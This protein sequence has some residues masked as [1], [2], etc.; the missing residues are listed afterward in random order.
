MSGTAILDVLMN[1]I[2]AMLAIAFLFLTLVDS[3]PAATGD[4]YEEN[5]V[6]LRTLSV[7]SFVSNSAPL[8]PND[9][10]VPVQTLTKNP[11]IADPSCGREETMTLTSL[12][13]R[14]CKG[15]Q[16]ADFDGALPEG[17][18]LPKPFVGFRAPG[19]GTPSGS[20]NS[21]SIVFLPK[22]GVKCLHTQYT[23]RY[24]S[25]S[26]DVSIATTTW[27]AGQPSTTTWFAGQPSIPD[28]FKGTLVYSFDRES[29]ISGKSYDTV[30]RGQLLT[31]SAE[32]GRNTASLQVHLSSNSM[33]VQD[34]LPGQK[35]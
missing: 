32:G 20:L 12:V 23:Y 3:P 27:F 7:Q 31:H 15:L 4:G 22:P 33:R 34:C 5:R 6:Y 17:V 28:L 26:S 25:G 18:E 14:R 16:R 11:D 29:P 19:Q 13:A 9:P 35:S 24:V 21:D 1:G 8:D 30:V 10:A 2:G